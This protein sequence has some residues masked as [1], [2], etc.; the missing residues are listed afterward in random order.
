[1]LVSRMDD[2]E[3]FI[4]IVDWDSPHI[5]VRI[6]GNSPFGLPLEEINVGDM[7]YIDIEIVPG[8]QIA[9]VNKCDVSEYVK[10]YQNKK[11]MSEFTGLVEVTEDDILKKIEVLRSNKIDTVINE[12]EV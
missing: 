7:F 8:T 2:R 6:N 11:V 4:S 3:E 12:K 9:A 1:M 10:L 5:E